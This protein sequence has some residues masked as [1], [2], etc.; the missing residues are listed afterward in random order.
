MVGVPPPTGVLFK[1]MRKEVVSLAAQGGLRD[2][3]RLPVAQ[4]EHDLK[5][6]VKL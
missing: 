2:S 5:L 1:A 4:L 3:G 6:V